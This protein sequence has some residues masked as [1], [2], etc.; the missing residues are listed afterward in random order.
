MKKVV[1]LFVV[2]TVLAFSGLSNAQ[3]MGAEVQVGV[4]MPM[5]TFGDAFKTGF[6]GMGTF[7]YGLNPDVTLTGAIGYYTF[8]HKDYSDATFST[9]PV[10][11]GARYGLGKGSFAPYVGAELGIH[12]TT[13]KVKVAAFDLGEFGSYGGG[14]A[15]A[16]ESVFGFSPMVGFTM[17]LSPKL[18]LDVNLKY[19]I[20]ST[21]GSSSSFLGIN[22]GVHMPL[23]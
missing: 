2:L 5:G 20:I 17:P 23:N 11:V 18:N 13:S 16:S 10:L 15:S 14:T 6:G 1:S 3:K 7:M 12:F 9:V 19:N 4:G 8:T 21:S 22:A